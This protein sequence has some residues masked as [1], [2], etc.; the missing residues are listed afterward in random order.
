MTKTKRKMDRTC[1]VWLVEGRAWA[2]ATKMHSGPSRFRS[3]V[4]T[5]SGRTEDLSLPGL[6]SKRY[7]PRNRLGDGGSDD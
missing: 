1:E 2:E 7:L 4:G 3:R 5:S 6:W